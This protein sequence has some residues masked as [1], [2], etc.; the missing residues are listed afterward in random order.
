MQISRMMIA[1]AAL[2]ALTH[3]ASA[4]IY[5]FNATETSALSPSPVTFSFSL[6]TATASLTPAGATTFSN[7]SITED[8]KT[9]AKN[10]IGAEFGT[11]ISSPLFFWI[12]TGLNSFYTGSG[13]GIAFNLAS[14]P[15]ADG[16]TD[17]EGTLKITSTAPAPT[18]EPASWVL[19]LTGCTAAA[20]VRRFFRV[21]RA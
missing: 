11:N 14:F 2:A 13:T 18:P 12:D 8:G 7:I 17:G 9:I 21:D 3:V 1:A 15:I 5:N 6:D 10:T 16:V 19:L 20:S 4:T